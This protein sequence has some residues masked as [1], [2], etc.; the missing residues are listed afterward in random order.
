MLAT[1]ISKD[2]DW[3]EEY[4]LYNLVKTV[5]LGLGPGS[6]QMRALLDHETG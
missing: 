5:H 1:E 3:V 6:Y 2:G 4:G